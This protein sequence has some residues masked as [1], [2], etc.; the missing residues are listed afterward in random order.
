[1]DSIWIF[2]LADMPLINKYYNG[3]H[4]YYELL[5]F[6]INMHRLFH[7]KIKK[8]KTINKAS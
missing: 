3:I 7:Q 2:D 5:M 6:V 8:N 1:M 4:C